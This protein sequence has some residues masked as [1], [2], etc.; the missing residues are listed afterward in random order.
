MQP[1]TKQNL[2][3]F[4]PALPGH[5]Q[6]CLQENSVRRMLSEI[7]V[8][9][10]NMCMLIAQDCIKFCGCIAWQSFLAN[11]FADFLDVVQVKKTKEKDFVQ[12][13]VAFRISNISYSFV[14]IWVSVW[15]HARK[16]NRLVCTGWAANHQNIYMQVKFSPNVTQRQIGTLTMSF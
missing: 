1:T 16:Q 6:G 9:I 12:S 2:D 15:K 4:S 13:L 7:C 10:Y 11:N 5:Q 3:F 8:H 14:K